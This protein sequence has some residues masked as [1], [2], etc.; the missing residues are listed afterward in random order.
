MS[1]P[2]PVFTPPPPPP[3]AP[4]AR[5]RYGGLFWPA[6]LIVVGLLALLVN[7]EIGRAHV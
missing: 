3:P 4:A 2:A 5:H 6:V 7:I 1:L